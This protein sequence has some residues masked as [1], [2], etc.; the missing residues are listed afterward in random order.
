MWNIQA[1]DDW[2]NPTKSKANI[3]LYNRGEKTF[4]LI[5]KPGNRN[6]A[7]REI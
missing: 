1:V 3:C 7:A 5:C 6:S 2:S 4:Q